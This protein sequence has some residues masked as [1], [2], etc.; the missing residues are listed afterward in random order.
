MDNYALWIENDPNS[1]RNVPISTFCY[2]PVEVAEHLNRLLYQNIP[3]LIFTS[4]TLSIRGSFKFFLN[5]SGLSLIMEKNVR[6]SIVESPFDY[7]KQSLLLIGSFLP[8]HKDKFFQSQALG[9]LEQ[10]LTTTNVGT[11]A[12]FTSY[13]D[14]MLLYDHLVIPFSSQSSFFARE[15]LA[16]IPSDEFKKSKNAVLLG[17][18]FGKEWIFKVIPSL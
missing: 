16:E 8:E 14:L 17:T 18:F 3:C 9:C 15:V 12:L 1:E 11:M 6:Q 7:D 2:A 4:A 10:I 5:Q 13:K